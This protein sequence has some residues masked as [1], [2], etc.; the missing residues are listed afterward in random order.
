MDGV[1]ED[2]YMMDE[3]STGESGDI[4]PDIEPDEY[5]P[6]AQEEYNPD[7]QKEKINLGGMDLA[8][9]PSAT[10]FLFD[11]R[12][13]RNIWGEAS[14]SLKDMI[15]RLG[16]HP[17]QVKK[18]NH[19]FLAKYELPV[20]NRGFSI[21]KSG[22]QGDIGVAD[23]LGGLP[24]G[25]SEILGI[26]G[27]LS[28]EPSDIKVL[29][30]NANSA[31][32]PIPDNFFKCFKRNAEAFNLIWLP[33]DGKDGT[34]KSKALAGEISGENPEGPHWWYRAFL[35]NKESAFGIVPGEFVA[36]AARVAPYLPCLN[37]L[38]SPFLFSGNWMETVYYTNCK[39]TGIIEPSGTYPYPRY[40]VQYKGVTGITATPTDFAEYRVGDRVAIQR[41]TGSGKR[42]WTWRDNTSFNSDT[43]VIAPIDFY[44]KLLRD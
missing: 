21:C 4:I 6:D 18:G 34:L 22:G 10:W 42:S 37:Q 7:T 1:Y 9:T 24:Y 29:K 26:V 25:S 35:K 30:S 15:K 19:V 16:V 39:I 14:G 43:W 8:D 41:N 40:L 23:F 17:C 38:S 3:D 31:S 20:H 33:S 28:S 32:A 44:G 13:V 5:N 36:M 27:E 11:D 2:Y 12:G